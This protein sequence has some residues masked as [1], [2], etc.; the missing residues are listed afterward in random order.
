MYHDQTATRGS[1]MGW[2]TGSARRL[3]EVLSDHLPPRLA[4]AAVPWLTPSDEILALA[5]AAQRASD[6]L[7]LGIAEASSPL[8]L[9]T[10]VGVRAL[11]SLSTI[12]SVSPEEVS[13][14]ARVYADQRCDARTAALFSHSLELDRRRHRM[15]LRDM[16]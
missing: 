5:E 2:R 10:T 16:A 7:G 4:I 11:G 13:R 14:R 1:D 8:T 3:S 12:P 6:K 15:S 9:L